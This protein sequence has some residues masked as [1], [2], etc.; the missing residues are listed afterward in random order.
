VASDILDPL[1]HLGTGV[2]KLLQALLD[3]V[4]LPNVS[5]QLSS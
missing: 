1:V 4:H 3:V 5:E 2:E